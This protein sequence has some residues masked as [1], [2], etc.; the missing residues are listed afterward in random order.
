MGLGLGVRVRVS[1]RVRAR[2]RGVHV[3][4][5]CG[6]VPLRYS[7]PAYRLCPSSRHGES[8]RSYSRVRAAGS[9]LWLLT[10]SAI[11]RPGEGWGW[12]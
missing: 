12:G 5:G 4:L 10:Y 3:D 11:A 2:V 8:T 9:L 7:A 6:S 1:V